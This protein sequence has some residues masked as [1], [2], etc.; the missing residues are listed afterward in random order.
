MKHLLL[1]NYPRKQTTGKINYSTDAPLYTHNYHHHDGGGFIQTACTEPFFVQVFVYAIVH[2]FGLFVQVP[3][4]FA[5]CGCVANG[6]KLNISVRIKRIAAK[7]CWPC[8][9]KRARDNIEILFRQE[10]H[11]IRV[12][13]SNKNK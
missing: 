13:L 9:N 10:Q 5:C 3:N 7:W 2:C 11:E 4:C 1:I 8:V 12:C 6:A